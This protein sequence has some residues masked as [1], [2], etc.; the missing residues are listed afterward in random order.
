MI[1][2]CLADQGRFDA[3][4]TLNLLFPK[5]L[6]YFSRDK[7]RAPGSAAVVELSSVFIFIPL[8]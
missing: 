5:Y 4:T 7:D 8:G 6:A 3:M 2:K 1:G